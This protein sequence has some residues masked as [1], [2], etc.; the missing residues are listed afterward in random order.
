MKRDEV[1][2]YLDKVLNFTEIKD[3]YTDNGLQVE[4]KDEIKKIS[5][6]VDATSTTIQEAIN[7]N[8]DMMICHHGIFWPS[9]NN[10]TGVQ[11]KRIQLL[12]KHDINLI[13]MH[14]PLDIHPEIGNNAGLIKILGA[15]LIS[16]AG[17]FSYLAEFKTP[18]DIAEIASILD[19][20]IGS[21][22][23]VFNFKNDI[24]K[25]A[26]CSGGGAGDLYSMLDKNIDLF[27][28]GELRYDIYDYAKEHKISLIQAGHY[29]TETVGVTNLMNK[30]KEELD[31]E[32]CF[33]S[34]PIDI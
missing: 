32:T 13:G 18:K 24:K 29:A 21:N 3:S 33:I 31:I 27:I 15:N 23:K 16:R 1:L 30:I 34:S 9:M 25:I 5:F 22:C 20:N 10:I 7:Q 19:N 12:L 8:C 2:K 6:S 11:K 17:K 14:I 26:V 28:T 4:G